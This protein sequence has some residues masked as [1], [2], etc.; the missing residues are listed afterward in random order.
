[1]ESL[2]LTPPGWDIV[3]LLL[4]TTVVFVTW[5]VLKV[6]RARIK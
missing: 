6:I 5:E 1:M 4:V 2:P 3:R